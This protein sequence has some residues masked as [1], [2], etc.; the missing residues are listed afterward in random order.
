L[1]VV[2]KKSWVVLVSIH[3][4]NPTEV[5]SANN[6]LI[7]D[8]ILKVLTNKKRGGLTVVSLDRSFDM[9]ETFACVASSN[10]S[11]DLGGGLS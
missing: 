6:Y 4:L 5:S 8:D 10:Q 11:N 7:I 1:L 2:E 3:Y 9:T